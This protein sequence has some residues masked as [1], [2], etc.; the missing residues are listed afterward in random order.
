MERALEVPAA[1]VF[2]R[3]RLA[4]RNGR[5]G[6]L[7]QIVTLLEVLPRVDGQ[8]PGHP[9]VMQRMP[10]GSPSPPPALARSASTLE[11]AVRHRAIGSNGRPDPGHDLAVPV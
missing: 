1:E 7:E 3:R 10:H 6:S 11:L 4:L 8:R 5:Q 2:P 9:Q